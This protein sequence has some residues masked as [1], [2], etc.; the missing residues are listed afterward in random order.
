[1]GCSSRWP[2]ALQSSTVRGRYTKG[3]HL[4]SWTWGHRSSCC[5]KKGDQPRAAGS[6]RG[7]ID[8]EEA[9][10]RSYQG[11]WWMPD[12]PAAP[13]KV[14]GKET[15]LHSK[16]CTWVRPRGRMPHCRAWPSPR[17]TILGIK[18]GCLTALDLG[19]CDGHALTTLAG[20]RV[21]QTPSIQRRKGSKDL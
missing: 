4:P 18:S 5:S 13:F 14:D 3:K 20:K 8:K 9:E 12:R 21:T 17:V 10:P 2:S 1:M 11:M 15:A 6:E 16:H 19:G 7:Q